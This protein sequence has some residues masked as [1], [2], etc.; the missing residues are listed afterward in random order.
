[1]P[2]R[3]LANAAGAIAS[4]TA[5]KRQ[6]RHRPALLSP[7]L[8]EQVLFVRRPPSQR[9]IASR[10]EDGG[11]EGWGAFIEPSRSRCAKCNIPEWHCKYN[12]LQPELHHVCI[13]IDLQRLETLFCVA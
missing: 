1:M 13:G 12:V 3:R 2:V 8:P 10:C 9:Y 7:L 4:F 11:R 6:R 5:A